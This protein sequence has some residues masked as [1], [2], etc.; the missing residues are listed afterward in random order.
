MEN[1]KPNVTQQLDVR[2]GIKDSIMRRRHQPGL[3]CSPSAP[4]FA[5]RPMSSPTKRTR[6]PASFGQEN[7]SAPST[8]PHKLG[9]VADERVYLLA[10]EKTHRLPPLSSASTATPPPEKLDER[11]PL[12]Q[13]EMLCSYMITAEKR[14]RKR[15]KELGPVIALN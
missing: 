5:G 6:S 13:A 14:H 3:S 1:R 8:P 7:M 10:R 9:R 2:E 15:S 12:G 11:A 4:S